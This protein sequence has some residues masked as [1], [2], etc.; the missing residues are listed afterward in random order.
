RRYFWPGCHR[1][2]PYLE[3]YPNAGR[4]LVNSEKVSDRVIVMPTGPAMDEQKVDAVISVIRVLTG[5]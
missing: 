2:K 3:L 1:L 4:F 5:G